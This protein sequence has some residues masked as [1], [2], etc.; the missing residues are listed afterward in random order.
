MAEYIQRVTNRMDPRAASED[1][2]DDDENNNNL[3]TRML[4]P[5]PVKTKDQIKKRQQ[6]ENILKSVNDKEE[7]LEL[8]GKKFIYPNQE[9]AANECINAYKEGAIAVCLIAQPGT[10]KT[11][12]AQKVM[13][14]MTTEENDDEIIFSENVHIYSGMSDKDWEKQ[15]NDS[16]LPA[17][18][19]NIYHR[20]KLIKQK[21]KLKSLEDGFIVTDECHVASGA[22]MTVAKTLKETGLLNLDILQKRNIKMLDISATPDA[23]LL[24]YKKWND[25]C[26]FV[27]IEPGPSYKGFQVMLDEERIIDAP[28][29]EEMNDCEVFLEELD[30][31]YK[32]TNKKYFI[33]RTLNQ[34]KINM[35]E[36]VCNDLGWKYLNH[37][38]DE[39][40][41]E[42]DTI[43]KTAPENHT[44]IF[45]KCFWKA[46]KRIPCIDHIGA[47]YE[48]IPKQQNSSNSAQSNPGRFCDNYEY[49][50]DQLDVNLRPLHYCDK[51]AI[52]EYMSWFNNDCDFSKSSYSPNRISSNGKG[53][54]SSKPTKVS[55][56]IVTGIN[57]DNS[58]NDEREKT[59]FASLKPGWPL[60]VEVEKKLKKNKRLFTYSSVNRSETYKIKIQEYIK[61]EKIES[62]LTLSSC[63]KNKII[64]EPIFVKIIN[65][66]GDIYHAIFEKDNFTQ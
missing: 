56:K 50:G 8:E 14:K 61:K 66:N 40:I 15:F 27:K 48:E 3:P 43:L 60:T 10:G 49:S 30:E 20:Q 65:H 62:L 44:I 51:K 42:I 47:T 41:H 16:V 18:R 54:V 24:D 36:C 34:E 64:D 58:V 38:S 9:K 53:K 57:N 26:K 39:R 22:R 12:T 17:F 19:D 4:I 31:R 23:V 7:L 6:R 46:S 52:E 11:G 32:K 37:N 21:D 63:H 45:I 28:P 1:D 29:L 33:F 13:I 25:K 55:E 2:T 59:Y 5:N 35:L